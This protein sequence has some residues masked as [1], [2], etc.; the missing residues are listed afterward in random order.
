MKKLQVALL[1]LLGLSFSSTQAVVITNNS[2]TPI[3]IVGM[4]PGN[5][6]SGYVKAAGPNGDVVILPNASKTLPQSISRIVLY[7]AEAA[8]ETTPA[9]KPRITEGSAQYVKGSLKSSRNFIPEASS[10]NF[11]LV[12]NGQMYTA[13]T[14]AGTAASLTLTP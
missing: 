4:E 11:K 7:V 9:S 8:T 5:S 12:Y 13:F 3:V 2:N 14:V 6:S 1:M 10:N